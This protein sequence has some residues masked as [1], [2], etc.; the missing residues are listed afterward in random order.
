MT[1][2]VLNWIGHCPGKN[3]GSTGASC[4][5]SAPSQSSVSLRRILPSPLVVGLAEAAYVVAQ[6]IRHGR[7]FDLDVGLV[8][9]ESE[10]LP[11][12]SACCKGLKKNKTTKQH[13]KQTKEGKEQASPHRTCQVA[14]PVSPPVAP[15]RNIPSTP[16][17]HLGGFLFFFCLCPLYNFHSSIHPFIHPF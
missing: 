6:R 2:G 12:C 11:N 15:S 5:I 13:K 14:R 9:F 17:F 16:S 10:L 1:L 7:S 4:V 3:R 8:W